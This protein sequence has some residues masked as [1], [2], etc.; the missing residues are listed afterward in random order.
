MTSTTPEMAPPLQTSTPQTRGRLAIS[1][2]TT[3][4]IHKSICFTD[5][6]FF[7]KAHNHSRP[8]N[9]SQTFHISISSGE[10]DAGTTQLIPAP[11]LSIL[12]YD[13][14]RSSAFHGI[15][16]AN[17][18]QPKDSSA[19]I[20][21]PHPTLYPR[22]RFGMVIQSRP[23]VLGNSEMLAEVLWPGMNIARD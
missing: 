11:A 21:L 23:R 17:S 14:V 19:R 22:I 7:T 15:D 13:S 3:G 4:K 16:D 12:I 1:I 10:I 18:F 6:P 2:E 9:S 8:T 5:C 20:E